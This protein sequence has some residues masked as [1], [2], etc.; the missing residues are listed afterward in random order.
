MSVRK[1]YRTSD[2]YLAAYLKTQDLRFKGT[3]KDG[4]RVFFIFDYRSDID[5]LK[6]EFFSGRGKVSAFDFM[7]EVKAMKTLCHD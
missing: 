6:T 2:L 1:D 5:D 3:H 4:G 7:N